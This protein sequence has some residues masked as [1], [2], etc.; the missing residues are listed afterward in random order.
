MNSFSGIKNLTEF[1]LNAIQVKLITGLQGQIYEVYVQEGELFNFTRVKNLLEKSL[2]DCLN[3]ELLRKVLEA[4]Q[5]VDQ[6]NQPTTQIISFSSKEGLI[7]ITCEVFPFPD[8][9]FLITL[10]PHQSEVEDRVPGGNEF[11]P[12]GQFGIEQL[13]SNLQLLLDQT[14]ITWFAMTET[15]KIVQS[16][17]GFLDLIGYTHEDLENITLP[18]LLITDQKEVINSILNNL[19]HQ[20]S[21]LRKLVFFSNAGKEIKTETKLIK[22]AKD[23][24]HFSIIGIVREN[25]GVSELTLRSAEDQFVKMITRVPIPILLIDELSLEIFFSNHSAID[26]FEYENDELSK[27]NIFDLFPPSENHYLV[28]VIRKGGVLSLETNYSW[29]LITK[30]G[31][32]KT[33]RFLTQQIDYENRKVLFMIILDT[34]GDS[35]LTY[36]KEDEKIIDYFEKEFLMVCLTPAGIITKVNQKYSDMIGKPLYKIIGRSF[37]EN[38]FLEDYAGV[39]HHFEQLTPQN[40]VRKNTN[41]MLTSNGKTVWVEW[42]DRGIFEGDQLVEIYGLGKNITDT[43]K[44]DLLQQSIEQRFQALVENLPMVVYVIHA[45]TFSPVYISPE[46]EKLTGY[47]PEEF[48]KNP[49]VWMN[50]MH[51]DDANIFYQLLEDWIEKNIAAPVEFR[52]Y[53]K[54]GRLRWVEETGTTINL[55]DGTVLFQGVSRDVTE[56]HNTREKLVYYSNFEHMINE[57]SLKL[58]N[59]NLENIS[60]I[61]Q[62]IVN[63]LGVYLQVDRSYIFDFNYTDQTMSNTFEWCNDGIRSEIANLQKLPFS[64]FPWWIQKMEKNQEISLETLDDLPPEEKDLK[65]FL[66]SQDIRS[67][68]VVPMFNNGKTSGFIGFDMVTRTTHWEN[69]VIQLLR[70]ASAMIT[71]TRERLVDLS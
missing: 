39:L 13:G 26:Y 47:T 22:V 12:M 69:E 8:Q 61:L 59:A 38:L 11:D 50:A 68:L 44:R 65:D 71:S 32:D 43:Y 28:S 53:H 55:P 7:Q 10:K 36:I 30:N 5:N 40:P 54:D 9:K 46:V 31:V 48:Y 24:N 41:R 15:G 4:I 70:I 16:N 23:R 25:P 20:A 64:E 18:D 42:T 51:P 17:Q 58:M 52:M 63:I 6:S 35:K 57:T 14:Q 62:N 2:Q 49:E 45:K 1:V 21:N 27:L 19:P 3:H 34:E 37:E 29:R 60:E 56:R 33:A 66:S 67:L